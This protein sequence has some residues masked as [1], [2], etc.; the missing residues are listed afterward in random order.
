[1]ASVSRVMFQEKMNATIM[2]T[3]RVD[4]AWTIIPMRAPV[5]YCYNNRKLFFI[6]HFFMNLLTPWTLEQSPARREHKAP[7][8][9]FSSSKYATSCLRNVPKA[10]FL[11]LEVILTPAVLKQYVCIRVPKP[12]MMPITRNM[13]EKN[14][15]F[16]FMNS[17]SSSDRIY[18]K[19]KK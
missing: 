3:S 19:K 2:P 9:F 8:E 4:M 12:A 11:S 17:S 15:D 1:M 13:Y 16:D 18:K 14:E 5:A 6:F 10:V 7:T